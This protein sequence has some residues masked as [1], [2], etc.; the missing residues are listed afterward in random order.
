MGQ[1][2][3]AP[4]QNALGWLLAGGRRWRCQLGNSARVLVSGGPG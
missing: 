2:S 3:Q 1:Q 4:L